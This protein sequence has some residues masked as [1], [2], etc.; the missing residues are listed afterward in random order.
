MQ[1][2]AVYE[3]RLATQEKAH[4]VVVAAKDEVIAAKDALIAEQRERIG[5]LSERVAELLARTAD[6]DTPRAMT[7]LPETSFRP[8]GNPQS[9]DR[10]ADAELHPFQPTG[11][12]EEIPQRR[13]W[14]ARLWGR[15]NAA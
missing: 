13:N 2:A 12:G 11:S 10:S 4:Q 8:G 9:E 15:N 1:L 3:Q 14:W 5:L 6:P 7:S